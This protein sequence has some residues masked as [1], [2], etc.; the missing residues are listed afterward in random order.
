MDRDLFKNEVYSQIKVL[1]RK[2]AETSPLI[3]LRH[4]AMDRSLRHS[5]KID[6]KIFINTLN[7]LHFT[8]NHAI[9][10]MSHQLTREEFLLKVNPEPCIDDMVSLTML[11]DASVDISVFVLKDLI[12]DDGQSVM[13]IPVDPVRFSDNTIT[14]KLHVQG[15]I[16]KERQARRF[17]CSF[18]DAAIKQDAVQLS[19]QLEDFT[20][21]ALRIRINES[22]SVLK[23]AFEQG[24]ELTV[25]L[26]NNDKV[27]YSG[28][29][30]Y[31]R[32]A[33]ED[34]S[35]IL[36]PTQTQHPRFKERKLRN[37][38]LSLVP[39]PKVSFIH[40]F[41]NRSVTFEVTD[42]TNSGFSVQEGDDIGQLVTGMIIPEVSMV[43][44]GGLKLQ[45]SAQV[46]HAHKQKKN[47]HQYGF[48]IFDMDLVTYNQF[49]N[50]Y[51]SAI[52]KH[53]NVTREVD[54]DALWEFFFKSGF[55]YPK[56]YENLCN[57]K[58]NFKQTYE[59]L[60][61][62]SPEIFANFTY[63]SNGNIFGHVS[64][65]KAYERTWMI[66]HLAAKPM[67][68]KRVGL[69]VLNHVMY[70]FDGFCR[71]PSTGMDY[72]IFY[73]RPDNKFPDY[74]FGGFCREY[75]NPKGCSMDCF[76]Y[77][78]CSPLP[79]IN[80]LPSGWVLDD[81]SPGDI[82]SLRSWYESHSGGLMVD[83]FCLDKKNTG[84]DSISAL[85]DRSGLTRKY[86]AFALKHKGI[87]QAFLIADESDMG[88]NL[89]EFLNSLKIIVT[90]ADLPWNIL[91][92]SLGNFIGNYGKQMIPLLVY[93][94][95]YMEEQGV[96][97]DHKYN[98]WVLSA[99][100]GDDYTESLKRMAKFR[101]WKLLLHYLRTKTSRK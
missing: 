63:Q 8:G 59:R 25:I 69:H 65:I 82:A 21:T 22:M 76:A 44:S 14:L 54:M 20:S 47:L 67:G 31:I 101:L 57:Y 37:P 35:V 39:T 4:Y 90:S 66:H 88:V 85:Y 60:Y 77:L 100:A 51:S 62:N 3:P 38:R 1:E 95:T 52:D 18:V 87:A 78:N 98:L 41:S 92:A 81:C 64:W 97:Y 46:V 75:N 7:Y 58:D 6:R 10:L 89:S 86:R 68:R 36:K 70:C 42:I 91:Y 16:S 45:C 93:P 13:I 19:G 30:V 12:I 17:L 83:A 72:M 84:K 2:R 73:F 71:L 24:K 26:Y 29:C 55:I 79:Q 27:V 34:N 49:F 28:A 15:I 53:A 32:Q 43:F 48:A 80:S 9:L 11:T 99:Q 5:R 50:I 94:H 23:P 96:A 61:R 40:P 33:E 56:K 74:F